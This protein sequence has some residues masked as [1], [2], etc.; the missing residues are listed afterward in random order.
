MVIDELIAADG[1]T[2]RTH[3]NRD[4]AEAVVASDVAE[5]GRL[6]VLAVERVLRRFGRE[7]DP[8]NDRPGGAVLELGDGRR[9]RHLRFHAVVDA[10][11]RDYLVWEAPGEPVLAAL[12][13]TCA[14]ALR[15]LIAAAARGSAP[16]A[17]PTD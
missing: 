12:A 14:A 9:V 8:D 13:T 10:E 7:L 11:A 5:L 15:H 1:T 2:A 3:L 6:P 4:G 16:P 17:Q